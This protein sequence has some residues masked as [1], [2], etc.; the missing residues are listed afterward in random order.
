MILYGDAD[1][2]GPYCIAIDPCSWYIQWNQEAV[3][4]LTAPNVAWRGRVR[5]IS[6]DINAAH[7][8][9]L[10]VPLDKFSLLHGTMTETNGFSS[11][12]TQLMD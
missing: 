9:D 8:T 7:I 6:S 2:G 11:P 1:G 4:P 12:L 3:A 5:D 10:Q